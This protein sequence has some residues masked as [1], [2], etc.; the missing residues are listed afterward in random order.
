M[1]GCID[2]LKVR[3]KKSALTKEDSPISRSPVRNVKLVNKKDDSFLKNDVPIYG[4]KKDLNILIQE[5]HKSNKRLP[6][7]L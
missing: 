3:N 4:R 6:F 1:A 7:K 2:N 5:R